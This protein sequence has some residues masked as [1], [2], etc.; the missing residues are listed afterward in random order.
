MVGRIV[1]FLSLCFEFLRDFADWQ[2]PVSIFAHANVFSSEASAF[3]QIPCPNECTLGE[4]RVNPLR[5]V[6]RC[7]PRDTPPLILLPEFS[8]QRKV[9]HET[10]DASE[11]GVTFYLPPS[12]S[13]DNQFQVND[14]QEAAVVSDT[15]KP[16][17]PI[18]EG[19]K[20]DEIDTPDMSDDEEE[21]IDNDR[22]DV[23]DDN[24]TD[25]EK[26]VNPIKVQVA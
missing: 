18:T 20:K 4:S 19:S 2:T 26:T 9:E 5:Q 10:E 11:E 7:P 23:D 25:F 12:S 1:T 14:N 24:P 15:N 17:Y 13:N 6:C 8:E 3:P 16:A 21:E 22:D